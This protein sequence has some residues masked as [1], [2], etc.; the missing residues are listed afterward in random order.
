MNKIET[1][2]LKRKVFTWHA[3]SALPKAS[4]D[5]ISKWFV[6]SSSTKKFGIA[7]HINAN[8]TLDFCPPDKE[9]IDCKAKLPLIPKLPSILLYSSIGFPEIIK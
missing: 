8:A 6:G 9:L 4:I 2:K 1:N 7:A 5:S 3:F